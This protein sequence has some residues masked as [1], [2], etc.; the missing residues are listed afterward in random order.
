MTGE[1][2]R[3]NYGGLMGWHWAAWQ[4]LRLRSKVTSLR[5]MDWPLKTGTWAERHQRTSHPEA[6]AQGPWVLSPHSLAQ[7]SSNVSLGHTSSSRVVSMSRTMARAHRIVHAFI[8]LQACTQKQEASTFQET[9][10]EIN[11]K[12]E[13]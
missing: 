13:G 3:P 4:V 2:C 6:S 12:V 7:S 11:Q 1:M 10:T 9:D 5:E 8:R